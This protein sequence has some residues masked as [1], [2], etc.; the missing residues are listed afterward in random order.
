[1][2]V[3]AVV[4]IL[5]DDLNAAV[6][7]VEN[8]PYPYGRPPEP[9]TLD[10]LY[11]LVRQLDEQAPVRTEPFRLTREQIA[12]LPRAEPSLFG[13]YGGT[14]G[15]LLGVPVVVVETDEESSPVVEGW[16]KQS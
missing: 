6:E 13:L 9:V 15:P 12:R 4:V 14:L 1:V 2:S 3:G 7:A 8:D 10:E 16:G 11:G 5:W